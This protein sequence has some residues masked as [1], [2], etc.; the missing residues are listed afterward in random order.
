MCRPWFQT[1]ESSPDHNT[2]NDLYVGTDGNFLLTPCAPIL[3]QDSS[4][5][6]FHGALCMDVDPSG[7]LDDY[8]PFDEVEQPQYLLFNND[9][10]FD[11][12]VNIEESVFK[13]FVEQIISNTVKNLPKFDKF[14]ITEL[15]AWSK[16]ARIYNGNY[17]TWGKVEFTASST[18]SQATKDFTYSFTVD[19]VEINLRKFAITDFQSYSNEELD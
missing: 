6:T 13:V 2:I 8:Y 10:E 14:E 9:E 1:Q 11:S 3:K 15:E 5:T 7:P 16:V 18:A 4:G 12:I 19:D 17:V